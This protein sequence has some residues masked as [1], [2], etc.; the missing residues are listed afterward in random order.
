MAE[1][2]EK[3]FGRVYKKHVHTRRSEDL[4]RYAR[5][6]IR[7]NNPVEVYDSQDRQFN[8]VRQ[9]RII[10]PCLLFFLL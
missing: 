3:D 10:L 8:Q 2:P 4:S 9:S 6:Q 1:H 5:E 7:K